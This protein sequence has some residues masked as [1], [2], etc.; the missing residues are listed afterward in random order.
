MADVRWSSEFDRDRFQE[1]GLAAFDDFWNLEESGAK[2]EYKPVRQ[3]LERK[4]GAVKR[5]TT[6]VRINRIKYF[7]KRASGESYKCIVREFEALKILPDF[8]LSTAKLLAYGFDE[9]GKRAFLI[10]KSLSG[11]H[12][13]EDLIDLKAPP[14]VIADFQVHK[15]AILKSI[16]AAVHRIHK[17]NY[18]Y[19]DWRA[20]HIF[21]RK[22][23]AE[24]VLIDLERFCHI[25]RCPW[26][27]KYRIVKNYVRMQEWKK[28]KDALGSRIYTKKFLNKLL[29]E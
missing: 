3:H 9:Q 16:A 25:G 10:F 20:K 21:I 5:Q 6:I 18:F 4:T 15:K 29:H 14:E 28:L 1:A 8:G 13:L 26:Y 19:P 2:A 24:V 11:Y 7:M 23:T 22:G 17:A 12:S 27:F